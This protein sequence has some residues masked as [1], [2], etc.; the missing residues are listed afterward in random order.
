MIDG[1][2]II[3]RQEMSWFNNKKK[4]SYNIYMCIYIKNETRN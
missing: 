4:H 1:Q 2:V 3:Q